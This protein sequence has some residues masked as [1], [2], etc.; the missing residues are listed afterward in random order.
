MLILATTANVYAGGPRLDY[1]DDITEEAADCWIVGRAKECLDNGDDA[2][3]R[4]WDGACKDGDFTES[5]CNDFINN[6]VDLG[7]H[8]QL[9]EQN[10]SS[11]VNDGYEDGEV[12]RPFN[13]D[14][15]SAG[16]G[17]KHKN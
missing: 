14:R 13:K 5:Q 8:E 7:D 9:Q 12:D 2:Y 11:C 4:S 1:G 17:K 10:I 16:R 6:P 15:D 3:N